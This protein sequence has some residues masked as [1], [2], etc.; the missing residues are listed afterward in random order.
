MV[1][2]TFDVLSADGTSTTVTVTI[3]GTNDAPL[4]GGTA[5]DA[6]TDSDVP[7]QASGS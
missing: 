3:A 2:E 6:I 4:I 7:P 5:S 1:T